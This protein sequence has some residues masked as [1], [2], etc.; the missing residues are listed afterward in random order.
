M[1]GT[2]LL[3]VPFLRLLPLWQSW[4]V[5][6]QIVAALN[7]ATVGLREQ[8]EALTILD[9]TAL[10][11][12]GLSLV[13]PAALNVHSAHTYNLHCRQVAHISTELLFL[14]IA[15]PVPLTSMTCVVDTLRQHMQVRLLHL[16]NAL[17]SAT[18]QVL[19]DLEALVDLVTTRAH[20]AESKAQQLQH[21]LTAAQSAADQASAKHQASSKQ[22]DVSKKEAS[23]AKRV[24]SQTL[25][26][27][28]A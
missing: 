8:L 6:E 17:H 16:T 25:L 15:S 20:D 28:S 19:E 12:P 24:R 14:H 23:A 3:L 18:V 26:Y 4:L 2:P 7:G 22:L 21:D 27:C 13:C 5:A 11:W 10:T 9:E 1:N